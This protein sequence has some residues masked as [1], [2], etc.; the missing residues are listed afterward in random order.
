MSYSKFR[1]P[2]YTAYYYFSRILY[3]QYVNE[4]S[5]TPLYSPQA[6]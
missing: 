2:K 1:I 3:F 6:L 5:G 4:L